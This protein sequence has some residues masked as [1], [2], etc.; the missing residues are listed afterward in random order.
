MVSRYP[1]LISKQTSMADC[2]R[3]TFRV[4]PAHLTRDPEVSV[5]LSHSGQTGFKKALIP[6]DQ[7]KT[8]RLLRDQ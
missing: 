4:N 3:I 2:Y 8:C 5:F 1:A 6:R 7:L